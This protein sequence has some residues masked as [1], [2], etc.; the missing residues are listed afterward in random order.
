MKT[1]KPFE[2]KIDSISRRIGFFAIL[3][4]VVVLH[5]YIAKWAFANMVSS[6]ADRTEIAD[7]AV[8]L[9]PGDPQT[10]YAAAVLY[11]KTF[12]PQDQ[13]RSLS[14]YE[15]AVSRAPEN[16]LLWLEYGKALARGG[17]ADRAETALR[18]AEELAP[19]YSVVHWTL[20]NALVRNGKLDQGFA[21]ISR[22]IA[23]DPSYASPAV[24]M[25]F[26]LYEGDLSQIR[27]VVGE[28]PG[29]KG[30]LALAL[31]KAKRYDEAV[32]VWN[33]IPSASIDDTLLEVRHSLSGELLSAKKFRLA[34]SVNGA[35]NDS[36]GP[37]PSQIYDGGFEQGIKIDNASIFEWQIT[38][39]T[40]P[41]VVQNT[42]QPHGG[43][44]SLVLIFN[45][46]DGNGLRQLSQTIAVR[47]GGKYSFHGFYHSDLKSA[48][49]LIWQIASASSNTVITEVPLKDPAAD[50]TPFAVTFAVPPDTD[51]IVVRL[52][53]GSCG[54][55][56]CQI[57][58]SIWLDDLNLSQL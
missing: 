56:I 17:D 26:S 22:A 31:A 33:S 37:A 27:R 36:G 8:S 48:S 1:G 12:L 3:L 32:E 29:A 39:G 50:W 16:Y 23:S 51:G 15:S 34:E 49:P 47:P 28:S 25:A 42:R 30:A 19:T 4:V 11:D 24:T 5:W 54:S 45:S 43:A 18:H 55:A 7:I 10:H 20:G 41:Q 58:G 46:N 38:Q 40:Q 6:R 53:R 44:K 2:F 21:E 52:T 13:A 35:G 9:A 14:E 57:N